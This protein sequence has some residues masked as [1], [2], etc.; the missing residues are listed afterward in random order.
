[1]MPTLNYQEVSDMYLPYSRHKQCLG[2]I[3]WGSHVS[4]LGELEG[5]RTGPLP[6]SP[7]HQKEREKKRGEESVGEW[8]KWSEC[9]PPVQ[10]REMNNYIDFMPI[11]NEHTWAYRSQQ[12]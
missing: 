8:G 11:R 3:A 10:P 5:Q 1:M 4:C 6:P 7:P 12:C 9:C 2:E